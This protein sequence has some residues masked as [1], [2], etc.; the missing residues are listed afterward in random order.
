MGT[1][2]QKERIERDYPE[3]VRPPISIINSEKK[4]LL[5][6]SSRETE[7]WNREHP[8]LS[9]RKSLEQY[10]MDWSVL[11]KPYSLEDAEYYQ[12]LIDEV[13][14]DNIVPLPPRDDILPINVP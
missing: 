7:D 12:Q 2:E 9:P 8:H 10:A 11:Q 14:I 13:N 3:L 4:R 1:P 5:A 6:E